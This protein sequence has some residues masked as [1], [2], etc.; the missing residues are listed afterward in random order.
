[1]TIKPQ[2]HFETGFTLLE[3]LI[4]MTILGLGV[5]TLLQIF[6]QG[7]QL[8]ARSTART[9]TIAAGARVMDEL[10]ARRTL[11]D[12][13][14]NG[15]LANHGRWNAQVQT[16]RDPSPALELSSNWELKEVALEVT[17]SESGV[18]RRVDLKTLRLSKKGAP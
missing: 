2:R 18:E 11:M 16:V 17:V 7:L 15:K 12:G 5:V 13:A 10:L 14:Q 4:A 1:M 6:S 3:V 9:E 8:G